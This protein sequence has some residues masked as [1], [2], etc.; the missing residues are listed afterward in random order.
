MTQTSNVISGESDN[1]IPTSSSV[2]YWNSVREFLYPSLSYNDSAAS[3]SDFYKFF[4]VPG[5]AHCNTDPN[6]P[7][8]PFPQTNLAVMIDWVEKGN[9]PTTLNATVLAGESL[10]ENRQICEWPLRPLWGS[11]NGTM[12][13][14]YDQESLDTWDYDL[15]FTQFTIY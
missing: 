6:E 7:N 4:S 10:G 15:D 2:R 9:A 3:L 12:E 13:C 1:S 8:G 5:A 11:E 14:V